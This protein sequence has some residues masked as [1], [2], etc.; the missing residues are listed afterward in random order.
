MSAW[1]GRACGRRI[2]GPWRRISLLALLLSL[3][4]PALAAPHSVSQFQRRGFEPLAGEALAELVVGNALLWEELTS[5]Q[6]FDSVFLP[7]GVRLL[8]PRGAIRAGVA[9]LREQHI[10]TTARYKVHHDR[11]S[12]TFED[13]R[14]DFQIYQVGKATYAHR[15][16]DGDEVRWRLI[17]RDRGALPLILTTDLDARGIKPVSGR[18]LRDL[19]AGHK[20]TLLQRSTGTLT[21][22]TFNTDGTSSVLDPEGKRTNGVRYSIFQDQLVTTI[23]ERPVYVTIYN[24]AQGFLG[25]LNTDR[26]VVDWEIVYRE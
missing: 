14:F 22:M 26:G 8:R 9:T 16:R 17:P 13:E 6:R 12:T 20:L 2:A 25:A 21:E 10:A 3:A 7:S 23:D 11:V 1:I 24:T 19:V 5:R 18:R 4:L 15:L